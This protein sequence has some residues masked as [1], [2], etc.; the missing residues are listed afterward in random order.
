[1]TDEKYICQCC[2]GRIDRKT[3]TCEYCGTQYKEAHEDLIRIETFK[4]PTQTLMTQVLIER[5]LFETMK[6]DAGEFA[7]REIARKIS[8]ALT[9]LMQYECEYDP[10]Y[11]YYHVRGMARVVVPIDRGKPFDKWG[12][13]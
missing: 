5:E 3:M 8:D 12:E 9:G 6:D 4:N 13:W 1:M 10:V 2:G 7:R 11:R